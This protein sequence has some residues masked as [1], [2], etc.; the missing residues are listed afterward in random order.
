MGRYKKLIIGGATFIGWLFSQFGWWPMNWFT[1]VDLWLI[2]NAAYPGL[3]VL[4]AGAFFAVIVG[5]LLPY[6]ARFFL[7]SDLHD[8]TEK[9]HGLRDNRKEFWDQITKAYLEWPCRSKDCIEELIQNSGF[10]DGLPLKKKA[11]ESL[12]LGSLDAQQTELWRFAS[13]I[14]PPTRGGLVAIPD[15]AE[16]EKFDQARNA[17]AKFWSDTGDK[18]LRQKSL[19][20]DDVSDCFPTHAG[21]IKLLTYLEWALHRRL[22]TKGHGKAQ[23]FGL[24]RWAEKRKQVE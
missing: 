1:D 20:T 12:F 17:L 11:S 13:D 21:E 23:M 9:R 16:F 18:L 6:I 8:W 7:P 22:R 14:Y 19:T 24:Y 2:N 4:F 10:P 15:A 5:D 3:A